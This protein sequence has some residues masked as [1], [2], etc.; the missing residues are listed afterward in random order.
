MGFLIGLGRPAGDPNVRLQTADDVVQLLQRPLSRG[1]EL[2]SRLSLCHASPSPLV[3]LPGADSQL[4]EAILVFLTFVRA[5]HYWTKIHPKLEFAEDINELLPT[6]EALAGCI[7]KDPEAARASISLSILEELPKLREKADKAVS[8][9]AAIVDSSDDAIVSKNLNGIITSWNKTAEKLFGY[10]AAEA[11]GQHISLI[12]PVD[13][14]NE[15]PL[16]SIEF[17]AVNV[18]NISTRFAYVRMVSSSTW[19]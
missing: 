2:E 1:Q 9:L 11:L 19:L 5:A 10:S 17:A 6:H 15:E 13:Q 16:P 12:I 4:E 3:D 8:L 14:I 18:S 7:L